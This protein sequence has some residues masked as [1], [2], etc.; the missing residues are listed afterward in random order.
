MSFGDEIVVKK[1]R[2]VKSF[3]ANFDKIS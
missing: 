1:A 2:Q 3:K